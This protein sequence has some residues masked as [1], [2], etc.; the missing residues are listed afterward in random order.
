MCT[1]DY[2]Q[3]TL[4]FEVIPNAKQ[5]NVILHRDIFTPNKLARF[6]FSDGGA[7]RHRL[8][9][10]GVFRWLRK[11]SQ[12]LKLFGAHYWNSVYYYYFISKLIFYFKIYFRILFKNNEIFNVS[13]TQNYSEP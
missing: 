8:G 4:A 13:K 2:E 12:S 5:I 3:I 11:S 9:L 6:W 1:Y 7:R 10:E